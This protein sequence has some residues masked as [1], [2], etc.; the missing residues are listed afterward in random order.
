MVLVP[1]CGISKST[2]REASY[3]S[4]AFVCYSTRSEVYERGIHV[5]C[6]TKIKIL[7]RDLVAHPAI[8][9][10]V[11]PLLSHMLYEFIVL[12]DFTGDLSFTGPY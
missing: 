4:E 7:E 8:L 6:S 3:V 9:W 10:T 12:Q 5:L 1:G 2:V 11:A